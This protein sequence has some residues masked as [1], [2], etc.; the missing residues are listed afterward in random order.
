MLASMEC[1]TSKTCQK[2]ETASQASSWTVRKNKYL[3]LGL[4]EACAAQAAWGHQLGFAPHEHVR[5][6]RTVL[7][8]INPPCTE[9]APIVAEFPV[10]GAGGWRKHPVA[11]IGG[12]GREPWSAPGSAN[13]SGAGYEMTP[14]G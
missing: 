6:G 13:D 2:P 9:C 8:G 3:V 5:S 14:G 7:E 11:M 12:Y 1:R 4:C 10:E